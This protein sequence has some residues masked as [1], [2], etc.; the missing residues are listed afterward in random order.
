MGTRADFYVGR[1]KTAEWL[2]SIAWDGYPAGLWPNKD[3]ATAKADIPKTPVIAATAE[4]AY[5]K[6]VDELLAS[7]TMPLGPKTV[8]LGLGTIVIPPITLMPSTLAKF[9]ELASGMDGG[10]PQRNQQ[11]TTP[12]RTSNGPT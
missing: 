11:R 4:E 9:G 10:Q 7:R 5:R 12:Q 8:G 3:T 6:A 2:G 1:G